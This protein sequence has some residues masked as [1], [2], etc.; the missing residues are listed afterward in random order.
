M[1]AQRIKNTPRQ[2][3]ATALA[4]AK[5]ISRDSVLKPGDLKA[6]E[7]SLL[8]KAG[9]LLEIIKGWYL[10]TKPGSDG[11]S[12]AWFGGF[13][14]FL[15]HYL[16]DRFG[17]DYCLSAESSLNLHAG[18]NTIA[19]QIIVMTKKVS[20][21]AL[22]LP[23]NTSLLLCTDAKSFSEEKEKKYGVNILS[24]AQA[25][26]RASPTY[27]RNK[28]R[29]VELLLK[30]LPS[31]SEISRVLLSKPTVS[32]AARLAGA[33]EALGDSH[34][35]NQIVQD[36]EAAGYTIKPTNPFERYEAKLK[37]IERLASPHA[38]RIKVLWQSM[39]SAILEHFP[40]SPG[41]HE[42]L[43]TS[44]N[45][46][47]EIYTQDAYHSLSIEGYQVTEELIGKI[48]SGEWDPVKDEKDREQWNA[49]AAK[50]YHQAF[51]KILGSIKKIF[52]REN[53][54][55]IVEKDL[56]SWYRELF[57]PFV[58]AGYF[59]AVALA[60]FRNQQVYISQS[61]YT[62]PQKDVVA[63]CMNTLF[64]LLRAE[65]EPAV[66]AILGH[67][68]FV[69][70]HPYMDGNGRVGRFLMNLML[71]SGGYNWAIIRASERASYLSALE[72]ASFKE[73]I[74]PFT[75]FVKGEMGYWKGRVGKF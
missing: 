9:C 59:D 70:V 2:K 46:I 66:R 40:K 41:I 43:Q 53:P 60:G 67:F 14:A 65:E 57:S 58:K 30:C 29:N 19:D 69:Y 12:T 54:G 39:R 31:A 25:L 38:G 51:Q 11:T 22:K 26:V 52:N 34:K 71:I 8:F 61:R 28:S 50:G 21:Q 35:A 17:E 18:E 5:K 23:H 7:R 15:R 73:N 45:H 42:K 33:Y 56:Q 49:L 1:S 13:W 37:G 44:L 20:N 32:P 4:Q 72:Q 24:M 36:M 64:E 6:A 16:G 74:V 47:N 63:D 62:P 3:L 10:L 27:F 75:L 55:D 68:I 48:A